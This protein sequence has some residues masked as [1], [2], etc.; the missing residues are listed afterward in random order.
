MVEPEDSTPKRSRMTIVLAEDDADQRFLLG[1]VLR[2]DGHRVSE[3]GDGNALK[4]HLRQHLGDAPASDGDVLVVADL[5]LRGPDALTVLTQLR[6]EGC[7]PRFILMTGHCSQQVRL[8]ANRLGALAV[9]VKPFDFDELRTV[10][11]SLA[12]SAR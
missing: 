6:S 2:A 1:A 10:I 5:R 4:A 3:T 8:D 12:R 11:R 9:F 7:A